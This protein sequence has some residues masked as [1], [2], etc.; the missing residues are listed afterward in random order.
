LGFARIFSGKL[1]RG[2]E[3]MVISARKKKI[4]DEITGKIT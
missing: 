1:R 4:V 2:D 3:L